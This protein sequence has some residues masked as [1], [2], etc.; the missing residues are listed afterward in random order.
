ML[1]KL[2]QQQLAVIDDEFVHRD[3]DIRILHTTQSSNY[4]AMTMAFEWGED[5]I[6][7]WAEC[8]FIA[9]SDID[10]FRIVNATSYMIEMLRLAGVCG[11]AICSPRDEYDADFGTF[12]A[13]ARLLK[14][15]KKRQT[16]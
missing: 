15:I 4:G 11:V 14:H 5:Y 3:I 13:K 12:V 9:N 6:H 8:F 7:R 10:E 1:T 16:Q 2:Q